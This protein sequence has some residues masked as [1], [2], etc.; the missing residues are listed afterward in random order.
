MTKAE[1]PEDPEYRARAAALRLLARREHSRTELTAKLRQR[2]VEASIIE[3]VLD[4]YEQAGW[5]SDRRFA[6]VYARQRRELAYG[7]VKI[8]AE[9]QRRG[10]RFEPECLTETTDE[11]WV[12]LAVR[13]RQRTFGLA[14]VQGNWPEKARQARSLSQRGFTG[15]QVERALAAGETA[16]DDH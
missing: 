13:W 1:K 5:L 3:G 14:S 8:R 15:A 7:P 11:E 2:G 4:E 10:I 6:D 16:E 9:L 12:E